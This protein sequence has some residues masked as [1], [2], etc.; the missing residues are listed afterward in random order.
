MSFYNVSNPVNF[1]NQDA[2]AKRLAPLSALTTVPASQY[3]QASKTLSVSET[4]AG[5]VL[6]NG[7]ILVAVI[8]GTLTLP[9]PHEL[10][11]GLRKSSITSQ[12]SISDGD[13]IAFH[14][15]SIAGICTIQG[16]DN[17]GANTTSQPV[18]AGTYLPVI[19]RFTNTADG[20]EAYT[21]L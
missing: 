18:A 11:Q 13:M 10:I 6:F 19:I 2:N 9:T 1:T 7:N 17:A 21:V 8:N 3:F 20:Q 15:K 16:V 14:V 12:K 5:Y 4:L